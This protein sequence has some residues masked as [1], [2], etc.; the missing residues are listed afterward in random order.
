MSEVLPTVVD[1]IEQVTD[2][3]ADEIGGESRFDALDNWTSFAA[4]QLLMAIEDR[5]GV[6]L[7]L[8][9]YLAWA[10]VDQLA[11]GIGAAL[12]DAA[13]QAA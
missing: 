8:R 7:D 13:A 9:S 3:P 10:R 1:L 4:L 6:R 12:D 5:F 11:A 2:V